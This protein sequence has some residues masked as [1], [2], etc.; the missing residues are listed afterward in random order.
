MA[1]GI[2]V[3]RGAQRR[4]VGTA[5]MN[6]MCDYADGWVGAMRIELTVYTDNLAAIRL[7]ERHGFQIEGTHRGY[8][9]RDGVF[10]DA[11]AMARWNPHPPTRAA[12]SANTDPGRG[13]A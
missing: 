10:V 7:Y 3:A 2:S 13:P 6:A 11:H 1:L 9:L 4:G 12:E 8:A 5:M